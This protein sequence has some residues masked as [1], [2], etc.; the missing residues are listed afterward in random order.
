MSSKSKTLLSRRQW[1]K[2]AS[3]YGAILPLASNA[4]PLASLVSGASTSYASSQSPHRFLQIFLQGGWDSALATDPVVPGSAKQT[5]GFYEAAYSSLPNAAT[6]VPGKGQLI[7]G[8]GLTA[9]LPAFA[10]VPTAFINGM[11]VEVTAHELATAYM[12]S[13]QLSLSRS[14]EFE[15]FVASM[16]SNVGT[17]PYHVVLGERI[18]LGATGDLTPPLQAYDIDLLKTMLAGPYS[19]GYAAISDNSMQAAETLLKSLNQEFNK[20]LGHEAKE[21][22]RAWQNADKDLPE[23]YQKRFDQKVTVTDALKARY[24]VTNDDLSSLEG[25]LAGALLLLKSGLS[26]FITANF[27]GFDTH[28]NHL[29]LHLPLQQRF[30]IALNTLI[31][32]LQN[33]PDPDNSA[34]KLADTTTILIVSEFVRTPRFNISGGTD[35]WQSGSAI[36][37]G[38]G[39]KDNVCI[40][41]T[42]SAGN[43]LGWANGAAVAYSTSTALLPDH[44]AATM[45][46]LLGFNGAAD[47]ISLIQLQDIVA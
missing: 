35:H 17:F 44:L 7:V 24:G 5:Q 10:S 45:L 40:G 47:K 4:L 23:F 3:K 13:G 19:E 30:A 28:S 16:G 32:D 18:P 29:A 1:L 25:K 2:A 26:R 36:V 43:A 9:A 34:L 14:K 27:H 21:S 8:P 31:Q 20:R 38:K 46:R 12:Y 39:V 33:T 37:M 42:S 41:K 15:A 6:T 22:L 11:F